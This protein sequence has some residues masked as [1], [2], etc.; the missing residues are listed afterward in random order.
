V[1]DKRLLLRIRAESLRSNLDK[2][3]DVLTNAPCRQRQLSFLVGELDRVLDSARQVKRSIDAWT[4]DVQDDRPPQADS[5]AQAETQIKTVLADVRE[6]KKQLQEIKKMCFPVEGPIV[7]EVS[8]DLKKEIDEP[9]M[10]LEN[11]RNLLMDKRPIGVDFWNQFYHKVAVPSQKIF[12]EYIDLLGGIALRDAQFDAGICQV[13]DELI[14]TF[15]STRKYGEQLRVIPAGNE[16]V[17]MTLARIIRLRF[18]EWTIW[19]LPFTAHEFWDM[20]PN[21]HLQGWLANE[22]KGA[23]EQRDQGCLADAFATYMMGPAYAYATI[24]LLLAPHMPFE[25]RGDRPADDVRAHVILAMLKQM[26]T[27][28]GALSPMY[29]DVCQQLAVAWNAAKEQAGAAGD[30]PAHVADDIPRAD[31]LVTALW[32]VLE[33]NVSAPMTLEAWAQVNHLKKD[34]LAGSSSDL[35]PGI[36]LRQVLNA[37][38][39]ARVDPQRDPKM[40]L[41]NAAEDL[42]R[43]TIRSQAKAAPGGFLPGRGLL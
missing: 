12:S 23:V 36:E 35:P 42:A 38:W 2:L 31:I 13:A 1:T 24:V 14:R 22:I 7:S 9:L 18:P 40:D 5:L 21:N 41:T 32:K 17:K 19:A 28:Y 4:E 16:A 43:K 6:V 30:Q 8:T 39:L 15:Q 26:Q 34:L 27:K 33:K 37:A 20:G 11:V 3:N 10:Q 25:S 29:D